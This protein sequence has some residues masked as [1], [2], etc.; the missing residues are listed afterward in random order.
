MKKTFNE[1]HPGLLQNWTAARQL[2][3]SMNVVQ[4]KY[5]TVCERVIEA[6]QE[7]QP[8]LDNCRLHFK[9]GDGPLSFAK[10][11]WL[12]QYDTW[13]SGLWIW[14]ISLD[15]LMADEADAPCAAIWLWVPKGTNLDLEE[16]RTTIQNAGGELMKDETLKYFYKDESEREKNKKTCFWYNIPESRQELVQMLL[17]DESEKFV[18]C[19]ASHVMILARFIP[20]LDEILLKNK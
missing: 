15:E 16:A 6:V 18:E 13:P 4:E 12:T 2:E 17:D 10:K 20:V 7:Q 14:N 5:K 9:Q 19:I 8:E 11:K 1:L 3:N